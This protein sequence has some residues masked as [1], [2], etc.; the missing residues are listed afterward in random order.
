ML[1]P[2]PPREEPR[3]LLTE[4]IGIL[5]RFMGADPD[6]ILPKL[7]TGDPLHL[8]ES[9]AR[10]LKRECLIM[11]PQR[12]YEQ[13]LVEV[14]ADA[15]LCTIDDLHP[16]W[17]DDSIRRACQRTLHRDALEQERGENAPPEAR[18]FEFLYQ[19]YCVPGGYG[20]LA[21]VTFNA[22]P[23]ETRRTFFALFIDDLLPDEAVARGV[24]S[25]ESMRYDVW[26][27]LSA[28]QIVTEEAKEECLRKIEKRLAREARKEKSGEDEAK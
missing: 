7:V 20:R 22:L 4:G 11:D 2:S 6:E 9:C 18:R 16:D 19:A 28:L 27:C 15:S 21:S 17:V 14:A 12:L 1:V 8:Q 3:E 13:A 24:G 23:F 10:F 26:D 25:Y 5:E